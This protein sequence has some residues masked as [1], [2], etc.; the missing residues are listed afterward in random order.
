VLIF[1]IWNP[2]LT[3]AER[4]MIQTATEIYGQYYSQRPVAGA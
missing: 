4:D 1:D 3:A 2:L